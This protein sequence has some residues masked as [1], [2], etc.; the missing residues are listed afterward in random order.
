MC[1]GDGEE[2]EKSEINWCFLFFD[3]IYAYNES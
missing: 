2:S 1:G 3:Y